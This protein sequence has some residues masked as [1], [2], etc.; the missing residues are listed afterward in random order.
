MHKSWLL[1]AALIVPIAHTGSRLTVQ[2]PSN[3]EKLINP[4]LSSNHFYRFQIFRQ[5]CNAEDLSEFGHKLG[6]NLKDQRLTQYSGLSQWDF[7]VALDK[8][9]ADFIASGEQLRITNKIDLRKSSNGNCEFT[10][11]YPHIEGLRDQAKQAR[12]NAAIRDQILE[13]PERYFE[14]LLVDPFCVEASFPG[15]TWHVGLDNCLVKFAS[16]SLISIL[17]DGFNGGMGPYPVRNSSAVTFDL[18]TE[19]IYRFHE[20]FEVDS[21]YPPRVRSSMNQ[22][23]AKDFFGRRSEGLNSM[24]LL[25]LNEFIPSEITENSFGENFYLAEK[26][27][28]RE[29]AKVGQYLFYFTDSTCIIIPALHLSGPY[30]SRD[31]RVV[32]DELKDVLRDSAPIVS[33]FD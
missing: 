17:C 27:E 13:W 25:Q 5:D 18:R 7:A 24:E 22:N 8:I 4:C 21:K 9:D 6:T 32:V 31:A 15:W 3:M 14:S 10:G 29:T 20:L 28:N 30:R 11:S 33:V 2:P 23:A 19:K 1:I 16:D 26:C 12:L